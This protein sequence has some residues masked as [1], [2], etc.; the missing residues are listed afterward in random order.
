MKSMHAFFCTLCLLV[1]P[2]LVVAADEPL[3][4]AEQVAQMKRGVNIVG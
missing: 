4:A 1:L 3:S 2:A